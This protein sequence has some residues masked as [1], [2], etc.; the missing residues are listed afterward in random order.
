[1]PRSLLPR[2]HGAYVQLGAPLLAALLAANPR[3]A[4]ILFAAAAVA[5]FLTREPAMIALGLRGTKARREDGWRA[6][7]RLGLLLTL[8][9]LF[10]GVAVFLGSNR[11]RMS[12][13]GPAVLAGLLAVVMV[14]GEDKTL[15]GELLAAAAIPSVVLPLLMASDMPMAIALQTWLAWTAGFACTTLGVKSVTAAKE[16]REE[17]RRR[18]LSILLAI[19]VAGLVGLPLGLTLG[20]VPGLPLIIAGW[21]LALWRPSVANVRAIGWGLTG[22]SLATGACLVWISRT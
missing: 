18:S 13:G 21:A 10:G 5:L 4:S 20:V 1:M 6:R 15:S 11:V 17:A 3:V 22:A 8:G 12:V 19:T 2:E 14:R 7:R 9:I 16:E